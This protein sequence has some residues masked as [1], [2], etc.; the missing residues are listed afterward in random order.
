MSTYSFLDCNAAINGPGGSINLAAGAGA[1][2]EGVTI[3]PVEDKSIMMIGAGGQG[4]HS[5]VGSTAATVTVTLLKTSPVNALLMGMYNF[6]TSSSVLHGKNVIVVTDLGR[7]DVVT[8]QKVA[9]KRVPDINYQKE[10]GTNVWV[11]DAI[12]STAVLGVGTPEL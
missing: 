4:Q 8:C 6:Q 3:V 7:G 11:F 2:E 1:A 10:A 9:F 5:L 12:S